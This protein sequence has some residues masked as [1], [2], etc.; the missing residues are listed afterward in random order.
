MNGIMG[1]KEKSWEKFAM[2][3]NPSEPLVA[4]MGNQA[5]LPAPPH[6]PFGA[7]PRPLPSAA[8]PLLRKEGQQPEL[9]TSSPTSSAPSSS[10]SPSLFDNKT[11]TSAHYEPLNSKP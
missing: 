7:L 1:H 3:P 9:P 11:H 6:P 5:R 4:F 8:F 2:S 10:S